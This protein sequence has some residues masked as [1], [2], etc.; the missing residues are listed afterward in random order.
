M[1]EHH[2]IPARTNYIIFGAL[3]ALLVVTVAVAYI[4]LPYQYR[5]LHL[6]SAMT[7]ATIKAVLIVLYFMHVRYSNRLTWLFASAAFFWL[8]IL[9]VI[10]LSDYSTRNWLAIPGK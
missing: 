3:M 9:L 6:V 7:I 8:G 2:V 5:S 10:C 1:S 4:P